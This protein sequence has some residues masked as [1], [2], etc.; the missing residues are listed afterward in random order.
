MQNAPLLMLSLALA[1]ALLLPGGCRKDAATSGTAAEPVEA[2]PEEPALDPKWPTIRLNGE[3][4]SVRWSDGDSFKFKSGPH[5]GRGVR[6]QG[7]NTLESYGPVHRW[8][9]WTRL[10]LYTIAKSSWKLGASETWDCTTTGEADHYGRLLVNCPGAAETLVREGHGVVFS[11]DGD[12]PKALLA[13]QVAAMKAR[14]G[15]WA[16][17]TPQEVISSLHSAD[18][19]DGTRPTYNRVMDTRTGAA[20]E[21][22]HTDTYVTCQEVCR[23]DGDAMSCMTYVPFEIR[24]RNKPECIDL[25]RAKDAGDPKEADEAAEPRPPKGQ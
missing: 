16:K 6:L 1:A 5:A 17:G 8:G 13:V 24:Y 9:A 21:A 19:G 2:A 18:E 14:K 11:M 22:V 23:G 20:E 12:A 10:E 3:L 15:I 7:Y 4:M 25:K